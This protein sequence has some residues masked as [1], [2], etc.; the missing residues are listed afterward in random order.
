M[1]LVAVVLPPVHDLVRGLI[2]PGQHV[3]SP[4]AFYSAIVD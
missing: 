2:M 3:G 4:N 1:L